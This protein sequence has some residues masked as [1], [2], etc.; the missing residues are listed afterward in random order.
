VACSDS[1][2]LPDAVVS[3]ELPTIARAFPHSLAASD[4]T[5][6]VDTLSI[7]IKYRVYSFSLHLDFV[8]GREDGVAGQP[9]NSSQQSRSS[10]EYQLVSSSRLS[11]PSPP[12]SESLESRYKSFQTHKHKLVGRMLPWGLSGLTA[13]QYSL[14]YILCQCRPVWS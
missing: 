8:L 13:V 2:A 11:C 6:V 7:V 9:Q 10:L 5:V 12:P 14:S 4:A 1:P 3:V